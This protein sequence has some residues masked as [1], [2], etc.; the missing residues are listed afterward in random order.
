MDT[1]FNILLVSRSREMLDQLEA[2]LRG[3]AGFVLERQLIVNG[4][5][6]PLHGVNAVPDVLVLHLSQNW[7]EELAALLQRPAEQRPTL[8]VLGPATDMN[9]MRM[10]MQAGA[11][12][13]LPVPFVQTDL[14]EALEQIVR[15]R[16]SA[17]QNARAAVTAVVNSKGG[18]GATLLACNLAHLLTVVSQRRVALVDLD[19]Q[20]GTL[21]LYLDLYPQRGLGQALTN[22]DE[23]DVVALDGYLTRH[24]SGLKVL[25]HSGDESLQ[26][27]EVKGRDVER[28]LDLLSAGHDNVVIDLPRRID[29][30]S[31]AV[32]ERASQVVV[33]VQQSVTTLRDATRLLRI[34][35]RDVAVPRDRICVVVNRYEKNAPVTL[36]DIGKTLNCSDLTTV[37]N[38][39]RT[40]SECV[41]TGTPLYEYSRG[42]AVTRALMA[43]EG[44]LTGAPPDENRG[45]LGRTFSGILK[46]RSPTWQVN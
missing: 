8:I 40:V 35:R 16:L 3:Q 28:L 13:F 19:V 37:P 38:D 34:L 39:F 24:S 10:A 30:A 41:N 46:S 4:H 15:D 12:D 43:L 11:R 18:S 44:R 31:V 7:R 42:A 36:E 33:V 29:P 32:F 27:G 21:P 20:F 9:A 17:A 22:L 6:D 45:L 25:G 1:N 14:L 2:T 26:L 23:L 5:V